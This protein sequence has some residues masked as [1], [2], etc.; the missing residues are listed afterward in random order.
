MTLFQ[1]S[2]LMVRQVGKEYP[3]S[4]FVLD[5]YRHNDGGKDTHSDL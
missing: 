3:L 5:L 4:F 2:R 1:L